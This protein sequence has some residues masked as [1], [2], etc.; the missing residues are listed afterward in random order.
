MSASDVMARPS[1]ARPPILG[2]SAWIGADMRQREAE[3]THRLTA[4][5]TAEIE[6]AVRTVRSR[7]L[8]L[9]AIRRADFPLPNLGPT[10]DRLCNDVLN[11]AA[12]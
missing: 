9:A 3:W 12:S 4:A 1:T 11:G 7:G 5:E 6:A 10:L 8:D 2:P